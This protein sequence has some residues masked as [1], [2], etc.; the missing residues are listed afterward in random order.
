MYALGAEWPTQGINATINGKLA[1]PSKMASKY[2]MAPKMAAP[3]G[4]TNSTCPFNN[5]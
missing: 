4:I 3:S 1:A 5:P 2:K